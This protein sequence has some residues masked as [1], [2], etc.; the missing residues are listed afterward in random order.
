MRSSGYRLGRMISYSPGCD[1]LVDPMIVA[2]TSPF[3]STGLPR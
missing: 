1:S 3:Y 2:D